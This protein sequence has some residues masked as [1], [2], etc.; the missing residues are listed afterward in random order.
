MLLP[1]DCRS[2]KC[3]AAYEPMLPPPFPPCLLLKALAWISLSI[4][5]AALW[6]HHNA[7][8]LHLTSQAE[9]PL[10]ITLA[11]AWRSRGPRQR[12]ET[13]ART[14][15]AEAVIKLDCCVIW[16]IS[17]PQLINTPRR[18]RPCSAAAAGVPDPPEPDEIREDSD[19][20]HWNHAEAQ[21]YMPR[22]KLGMLGRHHHGR[23]INSYQ[24]RSSQVLAGSEKNH[25][26]SAGFNYS[27]SF[28]LPVWYQMKT[29]ARI[30][31]SDWFYA[32]SDL[33]G[34]GS[35][36][37]QD[38][39]DKPHEH[40]KPQEASLTWKIFTRGREWT[41]VCLQVWILDAPDPLF[42]AEA[43]LS[44]EQIWNQPINRNNVS[45]AENYNPFL[46]STLLFF[47]PTLRFCFS[48]LHD[49]FQSKSLASLMLRCDSPEVHVWL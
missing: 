16:V 43:S 32:I 44:A 1:S 17:D 46:P 36:R 39:G 25:L 5:S 15:A 23:M 18:T 45:Y 13:A 41:H 35:A 49:F 3:V 48:S 19:F 20:W 28:G 34:S 31:Y 12:V 9:L 24:I 4:L 27:H 42:C 2:R 7:P 14:W 21:N 29:P 40:M 6:K 10:R 37:K 38:R 47:I 11:R 33:C 26:W 8:H 22:L 30:R